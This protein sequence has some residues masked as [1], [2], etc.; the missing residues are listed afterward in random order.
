VSF[1]REEKPKA[2][3]QVDSQDAFSVSH[4]SR[5]SRPF[6]EEKSG[7]YGKDFG[8]LVYA[9]LQDILSREEDS[10]RTAE[11]EKI[12]IPRRVGEKALAG[13]RER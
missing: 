9:N 7:D 2:L 5:G 8:L 4:G 6:S 10:K 12:L 13:R 3:E 1:A 11:G